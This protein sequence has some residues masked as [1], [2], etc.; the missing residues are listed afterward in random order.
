MWLILGGETIFFRIWPFLLVWSKRFVLTNPN[1]TQDLPFS[2]MLRKT[3]FLSFSV[4]LSGI[5]IF[6]T[7]KRSSLW[8]FTKMLQNNRKAQFSCMCL[9][10][11]RITV[12]IRICPIWQ[13][14]S[15]RIVKTNLN[16]TQDLPF[17]NML[18]KKIL[19][20]SVLLY[21][22]ATFLNKKAN[23]LWIS[24]KMLK[25]T[26]EKHSLA[27]GGSLWG[28]NF[29]LFKYDT[30]YWFDKKKSCLNKY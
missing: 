9:T 2:N 1:F 3:N 13:V 11:G 16:F 30:F 15:K 22:I 28:E 24:P 19:S 7:K 29:F 17:W 4:L 5:A 20:I 6:L 26:T 8:I 27:V 12:F 23:S 18:K 10:L 25:K 21:G 14:W